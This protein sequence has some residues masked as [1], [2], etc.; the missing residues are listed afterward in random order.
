MHNAVLG[1]VNRRGQSKS[2]ISS[3]RRPLVE[4]RSKKRC[5]IDDS[6]ELTTL[7]ACDDA[8]MYISRFADFL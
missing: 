3:G 4:L 5:F 8:Y 6:D 7:T 2:M 1:V